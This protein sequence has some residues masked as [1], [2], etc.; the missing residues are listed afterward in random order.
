MR[1]RKSPWLLLILALLGALIG[2]TA[3]ELLSGYPLFAWMSLGGPNGTR[4]LFAFSM[5]P[6]FDLHVLRV[7]FDVAVRVNA[8]SLIGMILGV[9]VYWRM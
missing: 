9:L 3:G 6:A 2:G 1:N 5:L 8:G 7:G 4:Q